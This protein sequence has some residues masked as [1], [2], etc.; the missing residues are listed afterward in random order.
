MDPKHQTFL[1]LL[2]SLL[3]KKEIDPQ[4][5]KSFL[6]EAVYAK[7]SATDRDHID[8]ALMN[9][10]HLL[11]DIVEFRLSKLTPDASPQLQ[12]MIEELW[13]MKDRIEQKAGDVFKF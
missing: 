11:E 7:L 8:L 1:D 3:Y 6:N 10:G 12:T 4:N 9:L 13:V 2:L 5:P